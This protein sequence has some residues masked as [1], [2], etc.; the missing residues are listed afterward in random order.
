M[1][2]IQAFLDGVKDEPRGFTIRD[3]DQAIGSMAPEEFFDGCS[4]PFLLELAPNALDPQ[5]DK[6]AGR[7]LVAGR[8][9]QLRQN[10]GLPDFRVHS[11]HRVAPGAP[12]AEEALTLGAVGSDAAIQ[13]AG[14][15]VA[16]LH[17]V[18]QRGERLEV[19]DKG[20]TKGTFVEERRTSPTTPV[21]LRSGMC[22]RLGTQPTLILSAGHLHAILRKTDWDVDSPLAEVAG[23]GIPA[24]GLPFRELVPVLADVDP[25]KFVESCEFG[26]LLEMPTERTRK[27]TTALGRPTMRLKRDELMSLKRSK[28]AGRARIHPLVSRREGAKKIVIGRNPYRCDVVIPDSA[29]S[30]THA[31]IHD[32]GGE[33]LLSDLGSNN[34]TLLNGAPI[35]AGDARH[36]DVR[37]SIWFGSYRTILLDA[38]AVYGLAKKMGGF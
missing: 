21:P 11:L 34:G 3:L 15:D 13:I 19:Q 31:E 27:A 38:A 1:S 16:Q 23:V 30:N 32:T 20:A 36:V 18:L 14:Q 29:A 8:L 33:W 5:R 28:K 26:F 17:C 12:T 6:D 25:A 35:L 37:Q 4:G 9:S 2:S 7:A 10:V 24:D 22:I